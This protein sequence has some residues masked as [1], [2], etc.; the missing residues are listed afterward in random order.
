[1]PTNPLWLE[2]T[3]RAAWDT[4]QAL[5]QQIEAERARVE[6]FLRLQE[7]WPKL[8]GAL[9]SL[10]AAQG[11]S[12]EQPHELVAE[13]ASELEKLKLERDNLLRSAE[14]QQQ[15]RAAELRPSRAPVPDSETRPGAISFEQ[16]LTRLREQ[17]GEA[18]GGAVRSYDRVL[19]A[20]EMKLDDLEQAP[21]RELLEH[22]LEIAQLAYE[23]A[24]SSRR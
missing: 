7:N 12:S 10:K 17:R 4:V 1:M 5:R 19:D 9:V 21:R 16:F 24:R 6:Q 14:E 23:L 20:L 2:H 3:E 18:A 15:K 22:A 8:L 11:L 13:L